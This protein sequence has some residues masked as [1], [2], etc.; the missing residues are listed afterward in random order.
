ML[1]IKERLEEYSM[2]EPNTGCQ[3]WIGAVD[4]GGYADIR[5]DGR[6]MKAHRAAIARAYGISQSN[7]SDIKL[8]N[9][10]RDV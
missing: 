4:G 7:V 3:L 1:G 2:P 10:W 8:G 5:I 9:I 6:L